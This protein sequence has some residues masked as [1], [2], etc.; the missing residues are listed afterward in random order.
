MV[1][2]IADVG[3]EFPRVA[4]ADYA[5]STLARCLPEHLD[6][7]LIGLYQSA[8]VAVVAIEKEVYVAARVG[9]VGLK[10]RVYS[11]GPPEVS[12]LL[13]QFGRTLIVPL[14]ADLP[15]DGPWQQ[16]GWDQAGDRRQ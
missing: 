11:G 10:R 16:Q 15:T 7:H 8:F 6:G 9:L 4:S 1:E 12:R 3:G 2:V 13:H 5:L 14:G